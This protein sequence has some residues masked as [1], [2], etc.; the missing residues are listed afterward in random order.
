MCPISPDKRAV[1]GSSP[2]A[3][4]TKRTAQMPLSYGVVDGTSLSGGCGA[5]PVAA[6]AAQIGADTS[7]TSSSMNTRA[8]SF[9]RSGFRAE[10]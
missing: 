9:R 1:G 7:A 2:P 3:P 10:R 4:T 8:V 6:E 5:A